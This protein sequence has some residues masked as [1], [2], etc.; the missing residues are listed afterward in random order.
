M[1]WLFASPDQD[2]S[3]PPGGRQPGA[4]RPRPI[5]LVLLIAGL[6]ALA[7]RF[8]HL[9]LLPFILEEPTFLHW[10]RTEAETGMW[11]SSSPIYGSQGMR[12]GPSV[13][14]FYGVAQLLL[15]PLARSSILA[16]CA[17]LTA[18]H[19]ALAAGISRALGGG[20]RMMGMLILLIASS[21]FQYFWARVAWDPLVNAC[22]GVLVLL[23]SGPGA[24]RIRDALAIGL[25]LGFAISSHLMVMPVVLAT[26]VVLALE[27]HTSPRRALFGAALS[28]SALLV[29]L[30][31]LLSLV[32]EQGRSTPSPSHFRAG[33]LLDGLAEP[34]NVLTT[35]GFSYFFD[36]QWGHF[37]G[38]L[39]TWRPLFDVLAGVPVP[40]GVAALIG[41][42]TM[43]R[44][45]PP[46]ARRIARVGLLSWAGHA[47][48]LALRVDR[49]YSHYAFP[50]YWVVPAG[51]AGGIAALRRS[52]E[53]LL[54]T[55]SLV[56]IALLQLLFIVESN[57]YL[58]VYRGTNGIHYSSP[59]SEQ[60]RVVRQ[61]CAAPGN[62]VR[63]VNE[64]RVFA[65]SLSYI[66]RTE[67]VCQ[68]KQLQLC[69]PG[70]PCPPLPPGGVE[71]RLRYEAPIGGA[72]VLA[73]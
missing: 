72:L 24:L 27:Q 8:T 56:G 22:V 4:H 55:W 13:I 60:T 49:V 45:A 16:I 51:L 34:V 35:R 62:V 11:V 15:G 39:G 31:Y 30:P 9:D 48:L 69:R 73:P 2:E 10:A 28:G 23:L 40:L 54:A 32:E 12:Y 44:R 71:L 7:L 17:A 6:L 50:T 1:R 58:T 52:R 70:E 29:N 61:A 42:V 18:A 41:L 38:W 3:A 66:A 37:Q 26:G 43:A 14:W 57:S 63:L 20:M 65:V 59:L 47:L 36:H 53:V 67:P 19:V 5:D 25:L 68:G 21:P 46:S 64:T 33:L